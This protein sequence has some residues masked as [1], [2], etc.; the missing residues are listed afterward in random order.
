MREGE[1]PPAGDRGSR[2]GEKRERRCDFEEEGKKKVFADD[3]HAFDMPDAPTVSIGFD[4]LRRARGET[5][6]GNAETGHGVISH[7]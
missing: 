5:T 7:S 1:E 4:G 3:M 6:N 2:R